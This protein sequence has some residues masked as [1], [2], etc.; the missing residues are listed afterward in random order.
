[1]SRIHFFLTAGREPTPP[2]NQS[3]A[4]LLVRQS[5]PKDRRFNEL[6]SSAS[7]MEPGNQL[8]E[9]MGRKRRLG[10]LHGRVPTQRKWGSEP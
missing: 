8:Y 6:Q 5:R 2:R 1:M 7:V 9:E 3:L 4:V 10:K